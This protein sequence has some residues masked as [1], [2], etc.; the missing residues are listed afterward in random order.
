[1]RPAYWEC[2]IRESINLFTTH[3]ESPE[4]SGGADAY[5]RSVEGWSDGRHEA[6]QRKREGLLRVQDVEIALRVLRR[7]ESWQDA[8]R[9]AL[10][11]QALLSRRAEETWILT[12]Q[13]VD[14]GRVTFL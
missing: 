11:L 13:E 8:G 2:P 9:S 4:A 7:R 3:A 10:P 6:E 5:T 1:M 14:A 12:S